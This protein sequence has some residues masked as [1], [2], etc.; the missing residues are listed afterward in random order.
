MNV[1]EDLV[2]LV[3]VTRAFGLEVRDL[4]RTARAHR[5]GDRLVDRLEDMIVLVAHVRRVRQASRG[6]WLAQ[7]DELLAR[8]EGAGRILESR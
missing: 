2:Q 3:P 4:E 8:S 6:E 5:H 7:R 1:R